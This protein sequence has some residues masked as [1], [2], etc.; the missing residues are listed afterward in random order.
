MAD[1]RRVELVRVGNSREWDEWDAVPGETLG[2]VVG[3]DAAAIAGLVAGLPDGES[4]RCFSPAYALKAHGAEGVLVEI[5]FCFRCHNALVVVPGGG[6]PGLVA[7]EPDSP[8][9]R[10]LLARFKAVD[11][12]TPTPA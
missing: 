10:A 4:M 6:R 5:A 3:A 7:F 1:I 12:T 9:G 8:A 11:R 2:S